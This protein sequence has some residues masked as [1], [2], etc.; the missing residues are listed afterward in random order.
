MK[1][2][3]QPAYALPA[4]SL[5]DSKI[6]G[7]G[8]GNNKKSARSD[9]TK[10]MHGTEK[11]SFLT[12]NTRQAFIQLRQVFTEAPILQHFDSERTIRIETDVFGYA[13]GSVLS[14]MT[15]ETC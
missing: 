12:P 13:I 4:T 11:P 15:L 7:S 14:Q 1:T 10:P 3:S 5:D 8:G 9:F 6:V 2:S